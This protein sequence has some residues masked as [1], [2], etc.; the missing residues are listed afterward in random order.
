MRRHEVHQMAW[1]LLLPN[2]RKMD[3]GHQGRTVTK[4]EDETIENGITGY[5]MEASS[6]YSCSVCLRTNGKV[7]RVQCDRDEIRVC[8]NC[9]EALRELL[10][11]ALQG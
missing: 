4:M 8:P 9:G 11:D 3:Q 2:V 7:L 1:S 6:A 5:W 10:I